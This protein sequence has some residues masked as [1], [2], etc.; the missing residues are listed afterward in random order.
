MK[1]KRLKKMLA[2]TVIVSML[3]VMCIPAYAADN[4]QLTILT[5]S[6]HEFDWVRNIIGENNPMFK[7]D[8]LVDD[9]VDLHSFQP[10]TLDIVNVSSADMFVYNGGDS[11]LWVQ[12]AVAQSVNPNLITVNVMET[13]GDEVM[14]EKVV[15][16][17][18]ADPN[19]THC[20]H[21]HDHDHEEDHDHDHDADHDHDHEDDHDHDHDADH[22]CCDEHK[23]VDEHVWLSLE[24]AEIACRAIEK[25]IIE[26]D[27]ANAETYTKNADAYIEKLEALDEKYEKLIEEAP[28]RV[29]IF[30]DRFPFAYLLGDYD[31]DYYAAF[32]GCSAETEASFETIVFLA[33]KMDELEAKQIFI[34]DG[35]SDEIASTV[36]QTSKTAKDANIMMLDSLQSTTR[37]DMENG[38]TYLNV[39]EENLKMIIS[40]LQ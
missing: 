39:M 9:G 27:P 23:H 29:L 15:E 25:A 33:E 12:D 24:N 8:Y 20:A 10:N 35:A 17:M 30:A 36:K 28:R 5:T 13:L 6:F 26:L 4:K 3:C 37:S 1:L 38:A 19:H 22:A 21:D 31:V 40:A 32:N 16:G 2:I 34:I 7:V 18:Q 14:E 11:D